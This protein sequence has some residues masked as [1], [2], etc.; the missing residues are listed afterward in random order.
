MLEISGTVPS[1]ETR[2]KALEIAR[3]NSD[4]SVLDAL[5]VGRVTVPT[6]AGRDARPP[7]P[8]GHALR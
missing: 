8:R 1:A 3:A 5:A 4:L 7:Q 6:A 2:A